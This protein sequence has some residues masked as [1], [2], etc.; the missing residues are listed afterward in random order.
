MAIVSH[1]LNMNHNYMWRTVE[2]VRIETDSHEYKSRSIKQN[3]IVQSKMYNLHLRKIDIPEDDTV[4]TP[5]GEQR[6]NFFLFFR[7]FCHHYH[8]TQTGDKKKLRGNEMFSDL[9]RIISLFFQAHS[10]YCK[11]CKQFTIVMIMTVRSTDF[12]SRLGTHLPGPPFH[13]FSHRQ[14]NVQCLCGAT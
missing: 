11:K 13:S 9:F 14:R 7:F 3:N 2:R 12:H 4:R 5:L 8:A 1:A 6:S 10:C